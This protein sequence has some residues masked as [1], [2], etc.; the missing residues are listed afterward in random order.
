MANVLDFRNRLVSEY[1]IFPRSFSKV[2]AT[3]KLIL[4]RYEDV[5]KRVVEHCLGLGF[6]VLDELHTYRGRQGADVAMLVRRLRE[7]LQADQLV[8]SRDD[9]LLFKS[10]FNSQTQAQAAFQ[11]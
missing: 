5:D 10:R 2:A 8:C 3:D 7:R 6:F 4:T 1:N 9:G 11:P